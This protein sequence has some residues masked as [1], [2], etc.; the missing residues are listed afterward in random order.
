[1][2]YVEDDNG[3]HII[4]DDGNKII[5][6]VSYEADNT[7]YVHREMIHI[8][9][10]DHI[11]TENRHIVIKDGVNSNH[12]VSKGQLEIVKTEIINMIPSNDPVDPSIA[13]NAINELIK[14]SIQIALNKYHTNLIRMMNQRM[15]GRV[16]KKSLII[17]KTN[18]TWIK[19]LDVTEID[20]V[21]SLDEVLIQDMYIK[22][23]DRYHHAKSDLVAGSFNQLEFFFNADLTEYHC[24]FNNHPYNWSMDCF[25]H[26]L[27][28]PKAIEIESEEEEEEKKEEKVVILKLSN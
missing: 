15:K 1:M 2:P 24:Y 21:D 20:G 6:S 27:I 28:L 5:F 16:G 7:T 4:D 26:Y 9:D 22:R 19:L 12:A 14:S 10:D 25:F 18:H 3:D 8:D 11:N 23:T 13:E 17:P